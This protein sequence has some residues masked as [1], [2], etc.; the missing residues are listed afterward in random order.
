MAGTIEEGSAPLA[1]PAQSYQ[2]AAS[3]GRGWFGEA[4]AVRLG[5]CC[6]CGCPSC[7][8]SILESVYRATRGKEKLI[9]IDALEAGEDRAAL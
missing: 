3:R 8:K 4:V 5:L 9:S 6:Q 2:R 7:A 1:G